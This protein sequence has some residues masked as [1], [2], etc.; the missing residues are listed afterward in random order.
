MVS[1]HRFSVNKKGQ[2]FLSIVLLKKEDISD[3][4]KGSSTT[5]KKMERNKIFDICHISNY[6]HTYQCTLMHYAT[7]FRR[8]CSMNWVSFVLNTFCKY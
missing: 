8:I 7:N 3:L 2:S 6:I 1:K 4:N 5:Y